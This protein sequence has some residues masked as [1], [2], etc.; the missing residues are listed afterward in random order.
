MTNRGT[1]KP[2]FKGT[3]EPDDGA[4]PIEQLLP[5]APTWRQAD[6]GKDDRGATFLANDNEIELVNTALYLRRPLLVTGKPG[7]G[8]TSLAYAITRELK[9]G[10]VLY[11]PITTRTTLKDGLYLYDAIARLQDSPPS[12]NNADRFDN[13][14]KYIR[15]GPLGTALLPSVRPRV[16]IVDEID[17]SD[18][19]LPND[20]LYV[21]EE[22]R[23]EIPELARI[24]DFKS[25]VVVRTAYRD[26]D[27]T[28]YGRQDDDR[29]EPEQAGEI[30]N[31][32]TRI[33]KGNV[34][35]HEF[36]LVILTSNGERDFPPPFLRRCV[37][38]TMR[39]PDEQ[40]LTAIVKAHLSREANGQ[41]L[42]ARSEA[43]IEALVR[44]FADKR[45]NTSKGDL[46]TDQLLNAIYLVTRERGLNLSTDIDTPNDL[47]DRLWKYLSSSEDQA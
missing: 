42:I 37:R 46:A 3:G 34:A 18:I 26:E 5:A 27:E 29:A 45:S 9:L 22:G 33:V 7:T 28:T 2:I 39:E 15:L 44:R 1:F 30:V 31:G 41:E 4:S 12:D 14:G 38:L 25:E 20:L 11:W 8:K 43:T 16:L 24:E 35:C 13:I 32:K 36:P 47:I 17:K 21:F 23:F 10:E 6:R 19:D 40:R